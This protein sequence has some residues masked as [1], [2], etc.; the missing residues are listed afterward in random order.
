MF[1]GLGVAPAHWHR[2]GCMGKPNMDTGAASAVRPE[3]PARQGWLGLRL[4]LLALVL[5][6]LLPALALG[7]TAVWLA[8]TDQRAAA[9]ADLMNTA[10]TLALAVDRELSA[11][12]AALVT[13]AAS[14]SLTGAEPD[15]AA[16][17][18]HAAAAGR[19]FGTWVV[20]QGRDYRQLVNTR[21]PL[22]SSLPVGGNATFV[23][24]IFT[25]AAPAVSELFKGAVTQNLM[26]TVGAPVLGPDGTVR[27]VLDMPFN[28]ARLS[29]L[30][31]AQSHSEGGITSIVGIDTA[32]GG[33]V[34][35]ARWPEPE[36]HIGRP[37]S[38]WYSEGVDGKEAGLLRGRSNAGYEV[39][40]GV[41][42]V[43]RAP[44]WVVGVAARADQVDIVLRRPV[45]LL[46]MGAFLAVLLGAGLGAPLAVSILRPIRALASGVPAQAAPSSRVPEIE[47]L[48]TSLVL[49][50]AATRERTAALVRVAKAEARAAELARFHAFGEA[51]PDVL[52]MYD[53]KAERLVYLSPS[54]E[55]VWGEP[56][57]QVLNHMSHWADSIHPDDRDHARAALPHVLRT[58]ESVKVEYR[59]L[60]ASTGEL[61]W[62]RDRGFPITLPSGEIVGAGGIVR[63][64]TEE[65]VA[66]ARTALLMRE[67]DHRAKNALTVVL[68]ALR[69]TRADTMQGYIQAVEGRVGALA[70]AQSLLAKEHWD[71]ADL[72]E[73]LQAALEPFDEEDPG[74]KRVS[75]QGP[76]LLLPG[77]M[78]Q[79]LSMVLHE[80]ATN[81]T[82]YGALSASDGKV[83][84]KWWIPAGA[85]L[86]RL[87]WKETGG[88]PVTAPVRRGFGSRVLQATVRDQL[89]G[90]VVQRWESTGLICEIILPL[91]GSATAEANKIEL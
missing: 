75:L 73:L 86:L 16:F 78:V 39:V 15:F 91:R 76:Q 19:I 71:G 69:L 58:G 4:R 84:V 85:D 29:G 65:K 55:T 87:E 7:A 62:V 56:R 72:T 6:G 54:F 18:Q 20:L 81:A 9:E 38:A 32:T 24:Q 57:E 46:L 61:R 35:I 70:R 5:A 17:H 12:E 21:L 89:W 26:V 40:V 82:K 53:A 8:A 42:R 14:P 25:K 30:L 47:A 13:L 22:G 90:Q 44:S 77:R 67:V 49:A 45:L 11:A 27:Y 28:L 51:S 83:A 10:Q 36:N 41:A 59:I 80:L 37:T 66:A 60:R 3:N 34:L 74:R 23:D 1:V 48:R 50:E 68:A 31:A 52:W 2:P 79:P 63:D 43:P 64:V 88:P 33:R